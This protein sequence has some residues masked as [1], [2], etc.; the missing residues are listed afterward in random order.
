MH[1]EYEKTKTVPLSPEVLE[2]IV[3]QIEELLQLPVYY[4]LW[5]VSKADEREQQLKREHI[6]LYWQTPAITLPITLYD[7]Q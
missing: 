5:F 6:I 4:F 3:C 1:F 7:K 2:E